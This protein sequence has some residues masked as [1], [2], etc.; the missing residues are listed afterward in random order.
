MLTQEVTSHFVSAQDGLRLHVRDFGAD[1]VGRL[2]VVCLPG[3]SRTAADFDV[4]AQAL[5]D[6]AT[7]SPRRVLALDY[8]GRGLSDWDADSRNYDLRV[9]SNDITSVLAALGV[10]RA[11][12]IGTSRGGLHTMLLSALRPSLLAGA[13]L[14]D[15][16]PVIAPEGLGRIKGYIGK[17]RPPA[18]WTAAVAA[19]RA[20]AGGHF[21]GLDESEWLAYARLTFQEKDGVIA[22]RYDP[23]LMDNLKQLD[24]AAIPELWPQFDGLQHIPLLVIR[25]ANSD[26]LTPETADAMV[27]RHPRATLVTVAGQ[28]HAPLLM[29]APTIRHIADFVRLCDVVPSP[30]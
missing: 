9:E 22:G 21:T 27:R 4:L 13:V 14:N 3:L 25:G 20:I 10:D 16:G 12:F 29:D 15:I 24:L 28:G 30:A 8:R 1:E 7:A 19:L 11:V 2:P 17:V 18:D 23:G 5:S 26:L 6:A